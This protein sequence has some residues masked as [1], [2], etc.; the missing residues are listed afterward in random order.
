[1]KFRWFC[2]LANHP[3]KPM[4]RARRRYFGKSFSVCLA[5]HKKHVVEKH[6]GKM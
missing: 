4:Y 5:A 3:E 1:M 6:P 2:T